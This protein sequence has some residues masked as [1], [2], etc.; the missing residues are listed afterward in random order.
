MQAHAKQHFAHKD[1][2]PYFGAATQILSLA[3]QRATQA[4]AVQLAASLTF[5]TVLSIV[6]LLA[7]VLSLFT[8]FP[9]FTEFSVS[10]Q[11]K[12]LKFSI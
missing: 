7:V 9:L 3:L 4:K 8:A 11:S 10:L 6:P 12:I 1:V 5:T 2:T